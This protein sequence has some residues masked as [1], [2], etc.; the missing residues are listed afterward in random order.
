M[1]DDEIDSDWESEDVVDSLAASVAAGHKTKSNLAKGVNRLGGRGLSK[2]KASF[3]NSLED[4]SDNISRQFKQR[5]IN[6]DVPSLPKPS[7]SRKAAKIETVKPS[8]AAASNLPAVQPPSVMEMSD[9]ERRNRCIAKMTAYLAAGY[10]KSSAYSRVAKEFGVGAEVLDRSYK[11]AMSELVPSS[12]E[13]KNKLRAHVHGMGRKLF[14]IAVDRKDVKG[15]TAI[16]DRLC[17][18]FDLDMT[19]GPTNVVNVGTVQIADMRGDVRRDDFLERARKAGIN[20]DQAEKL[21]ESDGLDLEFDN[22]DPGEQ[23]MRGQYSADIISG[24]S[25]SGDV[26]KQAVLVDDAVSELQRYHQDRQGVTIVKDSA[27]EKIVPLF[28]EREK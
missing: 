25:V 26:P 6:E 17:R 7:A 18:L 23:D 3:A 13:T 8:P 4:S 12:E 24:M 20:T 22:I 9:D 28:T 21:L 11:A 16:L 10:S 5:D 1:A 2:P 14:K 15:G 27:G 19:P